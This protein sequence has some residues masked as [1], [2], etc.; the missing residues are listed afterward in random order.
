M[1]CPHRMS[2]NVIFEGASKR[3][4]FSAWNMSGDVCNDTSHGGVDAAAVHDV[5]IGLSSVQGVGA[6]F[7]TLYGGDAESINE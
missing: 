2:F 3:T 4:A 5:E 1:G 6:F 7:V